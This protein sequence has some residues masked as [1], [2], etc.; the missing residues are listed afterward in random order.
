MQVTL[1]GGGMIAHDQ[2]LPTLFHMQ[3][4]GRIGELQVCDRRPESLERLAAAPNLVRAFPGQSF[5]PRTEPF[6]DVIGAL[7]A[8]QLVVVAVP[9]AA[10]YD[11]VMTALRHQQH[12]LCVK[13]LVLTVAQSL[14]IEK[15]AGARGLM[16]GI[17]YH[18]RF[19]DRSLMA[20]RRYQSG[21]FGEFKLGT[22]CLLEKWYYRYSNFQ[23]WFTC[24]ASDAFTYIGCHYVD[25]VAFITG[26]TPAAI[27]V[28]GIRDK[29]PNGNEGWLWTD[30]RVIWNNGAC[31]NVQN[32]LGFPDAGPGSNTQS[33]TM[34]CSNGQVGA[35][36]NHS[37]DYRGLQYCYTEN[38]GGDG[39]TTYSEPSPDYFQYQDLGGPGLTPVGYG[40]R[41]VAYIAE[42]ALELQGLAKDARTALLNQW[43]AAGVMA[44]P[45]NS[46]YNEAVV[47]GARKSIQ[48]DGALI[49]L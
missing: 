41:S 22:A 28:Y 24:D 36:L 43:D 46:R 9:D 21:L 11:V 23:N 32:A 49:R 7:P 29:F 17:E 12:V 20:R 40:Y 35:W 3:R 14:D 31:L 37:D 39:A 10:H 33:L 8:E 47:E 48:Q 34:Y 13:P 30:A 2:I 16:V 38:P 19:D 42:R 26:L 4:L 1:I 18:K 15:E 44:T 25:L 5:V 27:S 45:V 6:A